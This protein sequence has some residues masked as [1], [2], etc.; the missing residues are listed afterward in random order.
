M[1]LVKTF[2]EESKG[3]RFSNFLLKE[4]I[5]N[6]LEVKLEKDRT[7]F[8]LWVHNE[9]DLNQ[10]L[11]YLKE[12][13]KNPDDSKYNVSIDEVLKRKQEKDR[14]IAPDLDEDQRRQVIMPQDRKPFVYKMT[15]FF[16]SMCLLFFIVNLMQ[17]FN[18]KGKYVLFT[19]I[20]YLL[21]YDSPD[22]MRLL[23]EAISKY[24]VTSKDKEIP[25]EM[26]Q[27]LEKIEKIPY[28][29]GF[30]NVLVKKVVHPNQKFDF[31]G[32]LFE[33]IREGQVWRIFSPAFLH[34]DFLH[35]IF[36]MLWLWVLGKQVEDKL[37]IFRYLLLVLIIAAVSNTFQY[38]MSGPFFLGYSGVIMG[39]ACFIWM[40]QKIAPWEGYPLQRPVIYFLMFFVLAMFLL[41]VGSFAWQFFSKTAM[42]VN[43][44]NTAHI[45]G[46]ITGAVLGRIPFF[47]WRPS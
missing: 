24:N 18:K 34:K 4:N 43:I 17:E 11:E 26:Q 13:E 31:S 25:L 36:N 16:F 35:I 39:L 15:F 38:L 2:E 22:A 41:Q 32:K 29:K 28:W 3:R 23:N 21:M 19:P 8:L 33:K 12:F 10:V 6:T 14:E 44:A 40:R 30:Y 9:D 45:V 7:V 47:A 42:P 37:S 5:D 1:R 27:E 46:G 20:Q